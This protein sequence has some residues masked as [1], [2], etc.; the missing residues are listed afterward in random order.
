MDEHMY[1]RQMDGH[2]DSQHDT[3]IPCNYHVAGYKKGASQEFYYF[4]LN[5]FLITI[6]LNN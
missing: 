3:T 6:C 2:T 5:V 4:Y 1:N